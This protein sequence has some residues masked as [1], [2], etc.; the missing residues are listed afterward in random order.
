MSARSKP[1]RAS[2]ASAITAHAPR[3]IAATTAGKSR[4]GGDCRL[5]RRDGVS[6]QCVGRASA[7]D[8]RVIAHCRDRDRHCVVRRRGSAYSRSTTG[9][10]LLADSHA[11]EA[12]RVIGRNRPHPAAA[13]AR[14]SRPRRQNVGSCAERSRQSSAIALSVPRSSDALLRD[15]ISLTVPGICIGFHQAHDVAALMRP[16]GVRVICCRAGGWRTRIAI[17]RSRGQPGRI[18]RGPPRQ[19]AGFAKIPRATDRGSFALQRLTV[20]N[21]HDH[22]QRRDRRRCRRSV[23]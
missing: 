12:F 21:Q 7:G 13:V 2:P 1:A 4:Q 6:R 11:A 9:C 17:L 15:A 20:C 14:R 19:I 3:P 8:R 18:R 23:D 16:A 22:Q 10:R 5:C